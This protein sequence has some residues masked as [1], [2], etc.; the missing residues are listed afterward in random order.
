VA[1]NSARVARSDR[2]W[3]WASRRWG[4]RFVAAVRRASSRW[5]RTSPPG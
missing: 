5:R 2:I 1:D 4:D 3:A